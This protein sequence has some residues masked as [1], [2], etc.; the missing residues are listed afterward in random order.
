M[1]EDLPPL[2]I[3]ESSVLI[4]FL[5][6]RRR[7]LLT[8][9]PFRLLTTDVVQNEIQRRH[10]AEQLDEAISQQEIE[11][12]SLSDPADL[13]MIGQFRSSGLGTGESVS[14]V[15]AHR[16][17]ATLG[18]DDGKAT[19]AALRTYP[20]LRC[21]TTQDIVALNIRQGVL[22][23]EEADAIKEEWR[24]KY[25]FALKIASFRSLIE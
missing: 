17:G 12:V 22:T 25:R 24:L 19:R 18:M 23:I 8:G 11:I 15:A 14:I 2:L 16:L 6:I 21:I 20:T 5:N 13:Q 7:D 3:A 9:L 4:N 1:R 10:Q